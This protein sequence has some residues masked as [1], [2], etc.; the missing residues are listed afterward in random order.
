MRRKEPELRERVSLSFN[1]GRHGG[2]G[3]GSGSLGSPLLGLQACSWQVVLYVDV[4]L[5][6]ASRRFACVHYPLQ[7][8]NTTV[9]FARGTG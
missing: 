1:Q 8:A 7:F 2:G 5:L 9:S 3:G 6:A 4:G